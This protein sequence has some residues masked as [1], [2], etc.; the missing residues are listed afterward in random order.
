MKHTDKKFLDLSY[1]IDN[2][3][4]VLT[5]ITQCA[6][7]VGITTKGDKIKLAVYRLEKDALY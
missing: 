2:K 4:T 5:S 6:D 3:T 7:L 1:R